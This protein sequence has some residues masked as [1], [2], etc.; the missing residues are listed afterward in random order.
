MCGRASLCSCFCNDGATTEIYTLSLHDALP[1]Y[2]SRGFA[3]TRVR[4]TLGRMS[5]TCGAAGE[6]CW[7]VRRSRERVPR[8]GRTEEHTTELQ[9]R[10][11]L[12]CR[13]LLKKKEATGVRIGT[14]SR[15]PEWI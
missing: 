12:V 11:K 2:I 7:R 10:R 13:L 1:I 15:P 6:C 14:I 9:S 4:G 5:G 8:D 3:F